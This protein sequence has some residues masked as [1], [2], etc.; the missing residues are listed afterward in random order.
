[1]RV[2]IRWFGSIAGLAVLLLTLTGCDTDTGTTPVTTNPEPREA[3]TKPPAVKKVEVGKNVVLEIQEG[4]RRVIIEGTVCLKK[5]PL[6]LFMCR[7]MTKEHESI[8]TAKVDAR[9]VHRALILA[10]AKE[11]SPV[12][13]EPKYRA[14]HGD[15]INVTVE[16][17]SKGKKVSVPAQE[18]IRKQKKKPT[19]KTEV[20]T[21]KWVFGGSRLVQNPL[22]N[23]K[24]IYMANE[25]DVICVSNFENAMMD[26]PIKVSKEN[27]DLSWECNE[28]VI[29]AV[30]TKVTIILEPVPEKKK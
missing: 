6:E 5:G 23:N 4:K 18:W 15:V 24:L 12:V 7:E 29:P 30:D 22:D 1:M 26:L 2:T 8:V 20:L 3:D 17:E 27:S 28:E 21:E 16:Y 25:G 9:E 11:G 14:A 10:G 13:F 19:D